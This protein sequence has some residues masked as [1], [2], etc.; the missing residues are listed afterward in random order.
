MSTDRAA[1]DPRCPLIVGAIGHRDVP[2]ADFGPL[3]ARFREVIGDL[4][5]RYRHTPIVVLTALA[6]GADTLA[7][8]A[9]AAE[10][11]PYVAC[12][13]FEPERY[14]AD[15][16]GDDLTRFERLVAGAADV[17]IIGPDYEATGRA[18]AHAAHVL[19]AFSDGTERGL[20]GG[21]SEIVRWRLN[22]ERH[23]S[24]ELLI[25]GGESGESV[26]RI[27]TPRTGRPPPVR[28]YELEHLYPDIPGTSQAELIRSER[29]AFARIDAFNAG[30]A[31]VRCATAAS[32]TTRTEQVADALALR[33]QHVMRL[34]VRT[35]FV[36][37]LLAA[38]AQTIGDE[39]LGVGVKAL[40]LALAVAVAL[41]AKRVDFQNRY[42]DYRTLAEGLRVY[43]AWREAGVVDDVE[44]AYP[45]S[46][47]PDLQW[48]RDVLRAVAFRETAATGTGDGTA[49]MVDQREYFAAAA[50]RD[51]RKQHAASMAARTVYLA[52]GVAA[53]ALAQSLLPRPPIPF[54]SSTHHWLAVFAAAAAVAATL[55]LAYADYR[56]YAEAARRYARMHRLFAVAADAALRSDDVLQR[57]NL[58]RY[59]GREAL[60]EHAQWLIARRERP[61]KLLGA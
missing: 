28:A 10:G 50:L 13:P 9:A 39:M 55:I 27:V 41:I 34:V 59:V 35:V 51:R 2:P 21:T 6:S 5:S 33:Y 31:A 17:R 19:V 3:E 38:T 37:T 7:A 1:P 23:R 4:R 44:R 46:Q 53:V 15:F 36:V 8:E 61:L 22:G 40:A 18:I 49:W 42:Q 32:L 58:L 12:L 43:A 54:G 14:R 24:A 16:S 20:V 11:V 25:A 48:I 56:G 29:D 57:R 47:Q 30:V 45:R 26:Y 52:G 60:H